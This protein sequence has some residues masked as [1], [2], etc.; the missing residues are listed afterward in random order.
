MTAEGG[1]A[2]GEARGEHESSSRVGG[3]YVGAAG[4]RERG[5]KS[6]RDDG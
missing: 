5:R 3:G 1:E 6:R 4:D 2:R